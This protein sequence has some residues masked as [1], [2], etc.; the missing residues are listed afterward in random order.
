MKAAIEGT[1]LRSWTTEPN[2]PSNGPQIKSAAM[3]MI[4][5]FSQLIAHGLKTMSPNVAMNLTATLSKTA[6]KVSLTLFAAISMD[7]NMDLSPIK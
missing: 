5:G 2:V 4:A 1:A 3:L 7:A 6:L